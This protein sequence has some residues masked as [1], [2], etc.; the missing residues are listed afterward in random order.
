MGVLPVLMREDSWIFNFSIAGGYHPALS[1]VTTR[2]HRSKKGVKMHR[3][4]LFLQQLLPADRK[5]HKFMLLNE[6][7]QFEAASTEA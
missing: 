6:L 4:V 2:Q 5:V 1:Y 3:A 7:K